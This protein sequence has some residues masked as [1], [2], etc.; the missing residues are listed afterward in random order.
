MGEN[1]I[2]KDLLKLIG[3][4][5]LSAIFFLICFS[6]QAIYWKII[7]GSYLT[8]SYGV[9]GLSFHFLNPDLIKTLFSTNHGLFLWHPITLFSCVGVCLLF[10][11]L[12]THRKF[13]MTLSICFV[14]TWYII[15]SWDYTM[16]NSFGNRGFDASTVFFIIG[17]GEIVSR[18]STHKMVGVLLCTVLI[19]WNLQ[20]LMQQRYLGWLPF[21]AEV[22][23]IQVFKN[24][25]KFPEELKRIR[26]KYFTAR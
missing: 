24:Y 18:L 8:N 2:K 11:R 21:S 12:K 17:W 13:L 5:C 1:D 14:L 20:L 23:Y 6:P 16:A 22:S 4:S 7:Y 19:S 15:A 10:L 3:K 25:L 26:T 9:S